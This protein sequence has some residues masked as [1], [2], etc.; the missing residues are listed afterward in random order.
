VQVLPKFVR[1]ADSYQGHKEKISLMSSTVDGTNIS[2]CL[3]T[4]NH[5]NLI[6]STIL[7]VLAQTCQGFE[8]IVSDDCSTDGTWEL[9]LQL[10]QRDPRIVPLQ[11]TRNCGMA[12]N[13]NF[14]VSKA[15]RPHIA[16]LHH[17]DLYRSDLLEKWDGV[18]QRHP[19]VGFVFNPYAVY[20]SNFI[21]DQPFIDEKLPGRWFL[22]RYLLPQWGCPVR[23]TAMI[24]RSYWNMLGGM[25]TQFGLL[26]DV[27]LWMRLARQW[28]VG[29]VSQPVIIVRQE[30][31][32]YYPEIYTD[33]Q[34]SWPRQRYLYE[35]HGIN[36][37][38]Y[39]GSKNLKG[40]FEQLKFRIRVSFETTKW[41]CYA[42]VRKKIDMLRTSGD[43]ASRYDLCL[44]TIFR[45]VLISVYC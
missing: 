36:R 31:P 15:T 4:Y 16:L 40:F 14:A 25:R 10:A 43:G 13:A 35:I 24:R 11:T 1:V 29:Y 41:L 44:L 20:N 7:S 37:E 21:Y 2:V 39:F 9:I 45:K 27:D 22:E 33:K 23:G 5:V 3:L 30:R 32:D 19:D 38:E 26:A 6:E 12:S 28:A 34:W 17:D 8:F 18:L 42:L